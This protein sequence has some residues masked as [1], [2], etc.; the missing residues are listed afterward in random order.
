VLDLLNA[1]SVATRVDHWSLSQKGTQ[2]E[3]ETG[4]LPGRAAA[5]ANTQ[6]GPAIVLKGTI[7][8]KAVL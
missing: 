2:K 8:N 7:M 3:E 4:H 1:A 6:R 5:R